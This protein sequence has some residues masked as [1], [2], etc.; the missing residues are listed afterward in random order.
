MLHSYNY[1]IIKY[2]G[3][4]KL[5]Y[6]YVTFVTVNFSKKKTYFCTCYVI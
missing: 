4:T 5:C 1:I 6:C 2:L 3:V